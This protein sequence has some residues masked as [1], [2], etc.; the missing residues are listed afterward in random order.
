MIDRE[1]YL[2]RKRAYYIRNRA[3]WAE[4]AEKNKLKIKAYKKEYRAKNQ[5]KIKKWRT[6]NMARVSEKRRKYNQ[7]NKARAAEYIRNRL[8]T[9]VETRLRSNLRARIKCALFRKS[10]SGRTEELVGCSFEFLKFWLESKWKPGMSW[11]NYGLKGWHIDHIRPLASFDLTDDAQQR[12][13]CHFLNLQPLWA[14]ENQS[15]GDRIQQA[16]PP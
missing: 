11:E 16:L 10:K 5:A 14:F 4:Y 15:K 9:S 13:A 3:A 8:R 6:E 2:E 1:K 12:L 7:A